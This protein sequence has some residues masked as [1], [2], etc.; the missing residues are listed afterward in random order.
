MVV[1]NKK[2]RA[3]VAIFRGEL[4]L[5]ARD[6]GSSKPKRGNARSRDGARD[7]GGGG[8]GAAGGD[9]EDWP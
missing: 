5:R 9:L 3:V 1:S 6:A 4:G 2:S 8:R 7:S